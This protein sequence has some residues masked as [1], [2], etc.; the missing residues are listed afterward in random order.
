ME[1]SK[2]VINNKEINLIRLYEIAMIG[3][4]ENIDESLIEEVKLVNKLYAFQV[5]ILR[6]MSKLILEKRVKEGKVS[7]EFQEKYL[8][9]NRNEYVN[10]FCE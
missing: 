7:V 8:N 3:D 9:N 6:A 2:I 10:F 1:D 4:W 5:S